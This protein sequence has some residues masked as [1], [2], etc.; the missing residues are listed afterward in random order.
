MKKISFCVLFLSFVVLYGNES[1]KDSKK[2]TT[3][4]S[5]KL[6]MKLIK[7]GKNA[8]SK[9][10][11][12]EGKVAWL[13]LLKKKKSKKLLVEEQLRLAAETAVN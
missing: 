11:K 12:R 6:I 2:E 10:E 1:G 8:A 3:R 13:K 9:E 7:A 5:H 4:K